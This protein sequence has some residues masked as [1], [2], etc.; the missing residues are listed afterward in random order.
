MYGID[1]AM[2]YVMMKERKNRTLSDSSEVNT[3]D[4]GHGHGHIVKL[5]TMK[6]ELGLIKRI[7]LL[8]K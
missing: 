1:S 2:A 4:I 3:G 6:S 5:R 8:F 7:K